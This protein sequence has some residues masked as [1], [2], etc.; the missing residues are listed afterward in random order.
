MK[1][2]CLAL[3]VAA[4][5]ADG[6]ATCTVATDKNPHCTGT[7]TIS[8]NGTIAKG[9]NFT[10]TAEGSCDIDVRYVRSWMLVRPT[11]FCLIR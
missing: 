10:I 3:T 7:C 4:V 1:L 5:T 11:L 9:Q 2:L 6:I 8:N